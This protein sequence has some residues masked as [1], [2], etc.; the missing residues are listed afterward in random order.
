MM[1][2]NMASSVQPDL[3]KSYQLVYEIVE[4]SGIGCH[5]TH[6]EIYAKALARRPGIGSSTVYRAMD[7]LRDAG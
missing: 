6:S 4:E 3:P 1:V 7:R 2:R 5:L